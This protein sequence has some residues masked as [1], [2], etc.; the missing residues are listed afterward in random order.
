MVQPNR[1]DVRRLPPL[2]YWYDMRP[3]DP[4]G[5]EALRRVDRETADALIR[6]FRDGEH[7]PE[8]VRRLIPDLTDR[9]VIDEVR[10]LVRI[11]GERDETLKRIVRDLNRALA[12]AQEP[13]RIDGELHDAV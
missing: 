10:L 3:R 8:A 13:K 9:A 12:P 11:A 7:E 2:R 1:G 5:S 6:A 4:R